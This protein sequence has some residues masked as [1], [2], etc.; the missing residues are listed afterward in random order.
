MLSLSA[1]QINNNL[2]QKVSPEMVVIFL[3]GRLIPHRLK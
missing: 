2:M 1:Q 3:T